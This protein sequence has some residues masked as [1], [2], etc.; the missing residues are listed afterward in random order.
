[1][2]LGLFILIM[3][4]LMVVPAF[5]FDFPVSFPISTKGLND[6]ENFDCYIQPASS[7]QIKSGMYGMT[8]NNGTRFHEG[9]DIKSFCRDEKGRV[10]DKVFA[11][12]SGTVVHISRENNGS[13][14]KYIVIEHRSGNVS[15]YTLYAHL[16]SV[17]SDLSEGFFVKNGHILGI[18][19]GTSS[20]YKF[21]EGTEH[22]HF[23]V[24]L[25]LG[26]NSFSE[27]Y[28]STFPAN[29]KN[30]HSFWNGLN[31]AGLDPVEFFRVSGDSAIKTFGDWLK[32]QP[33]AFSVFVETEKIPEI[34]ESSPGLFKGTDTLVRERRK[35]LVGWHVDFSWSG[36]PLSFTPVY[37]ISK[38]NF[39]VKLKIVSEC[40]IHQSV[41]R[42]M[43]AKDKNKFVLGKS[44]KNT[45]RIIFGDNVLN[46]F[47]G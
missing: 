24:G 28:K 20:V 38:R 26:R 37:E 45:L 46:S 41:S 27:W 34:L 44:L 3:S 47:D 32:R 11:V 1:M 40:Y 29:D 23:E 31:L 21:P 43:I 16:D 10:E 8:R 25:R 17:A 14:G 5:S 4:E 22:L 30:L 13:Y 35:P 19:G 18:M 7:G 33:I 9:I 12:V 2:R 6:K 15:F 36:V 39:P 42:G